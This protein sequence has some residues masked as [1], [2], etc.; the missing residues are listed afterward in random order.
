MSRR[1]GSRADCLTTRKMY[2]RLMVPPDAQRGPQSGATTD[3]GIDQT[4]HRHAYQITITLKMKLTP[5]RKL[6]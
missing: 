2:S 1:S 6:S 4:T 3:H 5:M